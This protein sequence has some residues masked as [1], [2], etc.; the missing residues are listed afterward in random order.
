MCLFSEK[1]IRRSLRT[2]FPPAR[3]G[4]KDNHKQSGTQGQHW[5]ERNAAF[6]LECWMLE[7]LIWE[8]GAPGGAAQWGRAHR[9]WWPG[10][11]P[12]GVGRYGER[13][14]VEEKQELLYRCWGGEGGRIMPLKR[15][16]L[17][18]EY[19]LEGLMLKLKPQYSGHLMQTSDSFEK[20]LMLGKIEGR[21]RQ[22]MTEDNR[23]RGQQRMRWLSG[24]TN[25]MDISLSKLR[26]LAMDT[27]AWRAAVHG[28]AKSQTQL[29][30]WT[31]W[32]VSYRGKVNC[33]QNCPREK[34]MS[35]FLMILKYLLRHQTYWLTWILA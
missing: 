19:S 27:E 8:D 20:T 24:I 6:R 17:A 16:M 11:A 2:L 22:R 3:L 13:K 9:S 32:T 15:W 29:S 34:A 35:T 33:L 1:Q 7:G 14:E 21:R 23:D 28:D 18:T 4:R 12:S 31:E 25:S 30:D 10:H 26:E 5:N